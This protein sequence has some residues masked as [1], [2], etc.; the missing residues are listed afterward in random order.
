MTEKPWSRRKAQRVRKR[1]TYC[2]C[3]YCG[4]LGAGKSVVQGQ[5]PVIG[6]IVSKRCTSCGV[7]ALA[8]PRFA[9]EIMANTKYLFI[10]RAGL[11][12][13]GF[14]PKKQGIESR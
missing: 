7:V 4:M 12:R 10:Q 8:G 6:W 3:G 9:V 13:M 14:Q 11:I 2:R 1:N 5:L